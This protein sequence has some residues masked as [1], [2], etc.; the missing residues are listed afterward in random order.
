V[1]TIKR[2]APRRAYAPKGTA[3]GRLLFAAFLSF[4]VSLLML[5]LLLF[6]SSVR[7]VVHRPGLGFEPGQ[8][9]KRSAAHASFG[10]RAPLPASGEWQDYFAFFLFLGG[11]L[12]TLWWFPRPL[13]P[14]VEQRQGPESDVLGNGTACAG[15]SE[16]DAFQTFTGR[17]HDCLDPK[18]M[19]R[20]FLETLQ[21]RFQPEQVL[22]TAADSEGKRLHVTSRLVTASPG[23]PAVMRQPQ[24]C[25]ALRDRQPFSVED[26]ASQPVC[27][28]ELD[29]ARSGSHLCLPLKARGRLLGLVSIT[30]P[31][32]HWTPS[33]RRWAAGYAS[34][35]A[36]ELSGHQLL[37]EA[38]RQAMMDDLTHLCNRRFTEEYLQRMLAL[39]A[40][41]P[42]PFALFMLDL[43]H[44]KVFN[45]RFGHAAGDRLLCAFAAA[46]TGELRQSAIA[47]RW[48]GEEF[49]VVVPDVDLEAAQRVAERIRTAVA[50]IEL[51]DLLA[52]HP[53]TVSIGVAHFPDNGHNGYQLLDAADRALYRAKEAGRNR[54]EVAADALS[55]V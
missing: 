31:A 53:L 4:F 10:P 24:S 50:R 28:C 44:F 45:D 19:E 14:G 55:S 32:Q 9:Y 48:G 25:P 15:G 39:G 18:E 23:A 46:V 26:T 11:L 29:V 54:V 8:T 33:R 27:L 16:L 37:A 12:A 7:L 13:S 51:D 43:D 52:E 21:Q 36:S 6:G 40:R 35:L 20:L 42:H 17:L 2:L 34:Q 47:A 22:V 3:K 38:Q 5:I 1:E 49:M 30:G 41:S